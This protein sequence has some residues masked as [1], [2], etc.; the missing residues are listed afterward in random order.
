MASRVKGERLDTERLGGVEN[1]WSKIT[2]TYVKYCAPDPEYLPLSSI[3]H[4][5]SELSIYVDKL[6]NEHTEGTDDL[7]TLFQYK[8][9]GGQTTWCIIV[10]TL[11]IVIQGWNK[12][13]GDYN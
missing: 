7:P 8:S 6:A 10:K 12:Q 3:Y 1:L 5:S 9:K 2:C 11:F 13:I 4:L